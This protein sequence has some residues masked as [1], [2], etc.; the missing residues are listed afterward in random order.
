MLAH[1]DISISE[2]YYTLIQKSALVSYLFDFEFD[3][4]LAVVSEHGLN[5]FLC[6]ASTRTQLPLS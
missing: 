1:N 3:N 6:G 2:Y 5:V 4:L